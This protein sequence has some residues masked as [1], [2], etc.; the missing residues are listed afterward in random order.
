MEAGAATGGE[1]PGADGEA[2]GVAE[3]V[4][5][6]PPPELFPAAGAVAGVEH[7]LSRLEDA[8]QAA[9]VVAAVV[10]GDGHA[11]FEAVALLSGPPPYLRLLDLG[12]AAADLVDG[13][14]DRPEDAERELGGAGVGVHEDDALALGAGGPEVV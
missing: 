3:D 12:L 9:Q 6:Q 8:E 14:A 4:A 11:G 5:A 7:D 2:D 1:V 10:E 13:Q